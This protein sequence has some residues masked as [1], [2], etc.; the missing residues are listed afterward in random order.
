MSL[1]G[2][3]MNNPRML[4]P[5]TLSLSFTLQNKSTIL[6]PIQIVVGIHSHS[7]L[8]EFLCRV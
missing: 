3:T 5:T 1:F 2:V 7:F 4:I 6:F 8:G